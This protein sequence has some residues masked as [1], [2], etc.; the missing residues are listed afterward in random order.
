MQRQ[1][2]H[3]VQNTFENPSLQFLHRPRLSVGSGQCPNLSN[4]ESSHGAGIVGLRPTFDDEHY[5]D[6]VSELCLFL[7]LP[8]FPFDAGSAILLA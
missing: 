3:F 1:I 6:C 7:G 4:R 5:G 8:G 2:L